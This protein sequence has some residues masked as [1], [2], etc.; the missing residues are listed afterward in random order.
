MSSVEI[1]TAKI[2]IDV[3]VS[4]EFYAHQAFL[5][6]VAANFSFPQNTGHLVPV[7]N[8]KYSYDYTRLTDVVD[9]VGSVVV[10][11]MV[12]NSTATTAN[13]V[14]DIESSGVEVK[15]IAPNA[16]LHNSKLEEIKLS[17][18]ITTIS[19]NAFN[20]ASSLTTVTIEGQSLETIGAFAFY[21]TSNLTEIILP[22]SVVSIGDSAFELSNIANLV[23]SPSLETLGN[24]VF[25]NL[26]SFENFTISGDISSSVLNAIGHHAFYNT[27]IINFDFPASITSVGVSSFENCSSLTTIT[28]HDIESSQ[29]TVINDNAFLNTMVSNVTLPDSVSIIG[30]SAFKGASQLENLTIPMSLTSLDENALLETGILFNLNSVIMRLYERIYLNSGTYTG[31]RTIHCAGSINFDFFPYLESLQGENINLPNIASVGKSES[32]VIYSG[33]T[34]LKESLLL[35][36]ENYTWELSSDQLFSRSSKSPTVDLRAHQS[37][38]IETV[39]LNN[40]SSLRTVNFQTPT[41]IIEESFGDFTKSTNGPWASSVGS[42][43]SFW[44]HKGNMDSS[45]YNSIQTIFSCVNVLN[46]K[47]ASVSVDFTNIDALNQFDIIYSIEDVEGNGSATKRVFLRGTISSIGVWNYIAVVSEPSAHKIY[48]NG[49]E[50]TYDEDEG[51]NSAPETFEYAINNGSSNSNNC[52]TLF[53]FRNFQNVNVNPF[54]G[55]LSDL[56]FFRSPLTITELNALYMENDNPVVLESVVTSFDFSNTSGAIEVKEETQII[57]SN[58]LL[59]SPNNAT[60][61]LFLGTA[62]QLSVL[63]DY[64]L[65]T[66]LFLTDVSFPASLRTI[67]NYAFYNSNALQ[68]VTF[69]EGPIQFGKSCFERC[70]NITLLTIPNSVVSIE[71]AAFKDTNSLTTIVLD[72]VNSSLTNLGTTEVFDGS[73]LTVE[74]FSDLLINLNHVVL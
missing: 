22:S 27:S 63:E 33:G 44:I 40:R 6:L 23:V 74:S 9:I 11:G 42:T 52:V 30:H 13:I 15:I 37:I 62:P 35:D 67:G 70:S 41:V 19:E 68:N 26:N 65:S 54:F 50:I 21:N 39:V 3:N 71:N 69:E 64:A 36:R 73:A 29:L 17:N 51:K 43:L 1:G 53:C 7:D 12:D 10:A 55:A 72:G 48:A 8:L 28:F 16:F 25:Y 47:Y 60:T 45:Q 5:D 57:R 4:H 49:R 18:M 66:M 56:R 2:N 34:H 31:S 24:N 46:R 14:N 38:F 58:A 61:M 32:G 20:S 59:N